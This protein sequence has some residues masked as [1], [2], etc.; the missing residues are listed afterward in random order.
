[1]DK[2]K[3]WMDKQIEENLVEPNISLGEAINYM[4]KRWDQLKG[5]CI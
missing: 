4:I 3:S 5:Q 1:M 2:L